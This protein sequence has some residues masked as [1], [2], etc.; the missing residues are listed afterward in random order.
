MSNNGSI[1]KT[2]FGTLLSLSIFGLATGTIAYVSEKCPFDTDKAKKWILILI[3]VI[4]LIILYF[5]E[6]R[7][8]FKK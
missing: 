7:H 6:Y 1:K 2:V 8:M 3:A 5:G 4:S